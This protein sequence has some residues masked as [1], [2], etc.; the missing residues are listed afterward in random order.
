[1][2]FGILCVSISLASLTRYLKLSKKP[3]LMVAEE[4]LGELYDAI[5]KS[6]RFVYLSA[7]DIT[8]R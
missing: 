1:M 2:V 5:L 3:M 4:K 7:V 8:T 6:L